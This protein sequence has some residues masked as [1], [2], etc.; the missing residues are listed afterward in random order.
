MT[1]IYAVPLQIVTG[2]SCGCVTATPTPQVLQ[3]RETGF[4]DVTMDTTKFNTPN[5]RV[6]LYVTVYSPDQ[7]FS[8]TTTLAIAGT[9]RQDVTLYPAQ[10]EFGQVPRGQVLAKDLKVSYAGPLK[11]EIAAA[12]NESAP[13]DVQ[14]QPLNR[15]NG[16]VD[17][18]VRLALKADAPAGTY[19]GELNLV[20]NDPNNRQVPIPYDVTVLAPLSASP[21]VT[22]LGTL[23]V[24]EQALPRKV[25]VRSGGNRPFRIL[26]VDGQTDGLS[27]E[28]PPGAAPV[29]ILTIKFQPMQPGPVERTLTIKTDLDGGA[30]AVKVLAMVQ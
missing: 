19:R 29:Q 27:V 14:V 21:D 15:Q 20:T 28:I 26:E 23:K 2:V 3:P 1:N 11:W 30:V 25:Y 18:Q 24:G 6:E 4:L 9:Y 17:Y 12:P 10:A 16:R 22:R 8:S 13:F 5:K 7:K